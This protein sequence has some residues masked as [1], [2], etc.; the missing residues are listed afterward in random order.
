MRKLIIIGSMMAAVVS[1]NAVLVDNFTTAG[2]M[3]LLAGT[4]VTTNIGGGIIGAERDMEGN[5]IANPLGQFVD[6][7]AAGGLSVV[8]NGFLT[9]SI[10]SLQYDGIG[11]E[12]GNTG[13]GFVLN[14][15]G[16]GTL[17]GAF[18]GDRVRIH[19][20]GNDLAVNVQAQ[21]RAGGVV[22]DQNNGIRAAMSG[23]G[24]M[25]IFLI[26]GAMTA[27]DSL[28]VRFAAAPSGDFA[29]RKIEVVPEPATM[30]AL[31]LGLA[32]MARRRKNA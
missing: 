5:V 6:I 19:F 8:S 24:F 11:D 25:D 4:A 31:G 21:V 3:S 2:G 16:A 7:S 20:L 22:L 30:A 17:G 27:A 13:P 12:I 26:P 18:A 32:A 9:Q 14:N 28:T 10:V 15:L 23:A 29:I 1:A